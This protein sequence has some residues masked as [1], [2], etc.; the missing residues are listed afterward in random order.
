MKKKINKILSWPKPT[1]VTDIQAFL[2][3]CVYVWIFI[4]LFAELASPLRRLASKGVDR[5]WKLFCQELFEVLKQKVGEDICLK[6]ID[7][8]EGAGALKLAVDSSLVAAGAVLMQ[9]DSEGW[10]RPILYESLTF[11]PTE[12]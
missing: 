6:G 2:G 1:T 11:T 12:A 8:S 7:Y 10:D 3:I 5:E 4:C 9:V